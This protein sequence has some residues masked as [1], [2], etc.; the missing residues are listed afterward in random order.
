M[1]TASARVA[2]LQQEKVALEQESQHQLSQGFAE[3]EI[4]DKLNM[5][6]P[7]EVVVILPEMTPAATP[8]A[9]LQPKEPV[10]NQPNW[11]KWLEVF[12]FWH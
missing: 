4:R 9:V 3:R 12:G 10:E 1:Q 2:K 8:T 5:A 6:K 7:G 11:K